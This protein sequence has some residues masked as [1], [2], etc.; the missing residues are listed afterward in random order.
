[1]NKWL[2]H[3]LYGV[4]NGIE[5]MPVVSVQSNVDGSFVINNASLK[6]ILPVA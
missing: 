3:Y 1:M 6:F 2:S 5:N 4:E